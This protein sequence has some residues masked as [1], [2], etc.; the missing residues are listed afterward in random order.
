MSHGVIE[1][2]IMPAFYIKYLPK[3]Q[4]QNNTFGDSVDNQKVA[5]TRI[6]IACVSV[7]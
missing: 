4:R 5:N 3:K 1:A 6:K 7:D 2:V